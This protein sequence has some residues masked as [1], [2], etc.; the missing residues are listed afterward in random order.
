MERYVCLVISSACT[1]RRRHRPLC[2]AVAVQSQAKDCDRRVEIA[3]LGSAVTPSRRCA[4][5]GGSGQGGGG[6]GA[7]PPGVVAVWCARRRTM[8][9]AAAALLAPTYL[10]S[11][12]FPLT[13]PGLTHV[14]SLLPPCLSSIYRLAPRSMPSILRKLSLRSPSLDPSTPSPTR[15]RRGSALKN[16]LPLPLPD[17]PRRSRSQTPPANESLPE[18]PA[19]STSS[20]VSEATV[21][22]TATATATK[23]ADDGG[24]IGKRSVGTDPPHDVESANAADA[25]R[26]KPG[27]EQVPRA[28]LRRCN[29]AD[30]VGDKAASTETAQTTKG[31]P[32]NSDTTST[33]ASHSTFPSPLSN[34]DN[35]PGGEGSDFLPQN[36]PSNRASLSLNSV[37]SARRISF[38]PS[39]RNVSSPAPKPPL[40]ASLSRNYVAMVQAAE[41]A[42][43]LQRSH[44][45]HDQGSLGPQPWSGGGRS[46]RGRRPRPQTAPTLGTNSDSKAFGSG[47]GSLRTLM[48]LKR[49][50]P[51]EA[52]EGALPQDLFSPEQDALGS[53]H[54]E[55]LHTSQSQSNGTDSPPSMG[56]QVKDAPDSSNISKD[57]T[58]PPQSPATVH[59]RTATDPAA[60]QPSAPRAEQA[61]S[62]ET[63]T[64]VPPSETNAPDPLSLTSIPTR[65]LPPATPARKEHEPEVPPASAPA[66]L[67]VPTSTRADVNHAAEKAPFSNLDQNERTSAPPT[68]KTEQPNES[69]PSQKRAGSASQPGPDSPSGVRT[70]WKGPDRDPS[71]SRRLKSASLAVRLT[72]RLTKAFRSRARGSANTE[73]SSAR[74]SAGIAEEGGED[75][76]P[77]PPTRF[78]SREQ[79]GVT[80]HPQP[81]LLA[82]GGALT[83]AILV[84]GV[85]AFVPMEKHSDDPNRTDKKDVAGAA[86]QGHAAQDRTPRI[87]GRNATDPAGNSAKGTQRL[88]ES[89]KL[90]IDRSTPKR[91]T[92]QFVAGDVTPSGSRSPSPSPTPSPTPLHKGTSSRPSSAHAPGQA[93][94]HFKSDRG[95]PV[96]TSYEAARQEET[97]KSVGGAFPRTETM[98]STHSGGSGIY[99]SWAR[100]PVLAR[101]SSRGSAHT[102]SSWRSDLAERM[103]KAFAA[104]AGAIGTRRPRSAGGLA[105]A[106]G[107]SGQRLSEADLQR[108][109]GLQAAREMARLDR[110]IEDEFEVGG[111]DGRQG[112][113]GATYH[114]IEYNKRALAQKR[115]EPTSRATL[116]RIGQRMSRPSTAE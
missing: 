99:S 43:R 37:R 81:I 12:T 10:R 35:D 20:A 5:S 11:S 109:R 55:A 52:S 93:S 39:V 19:A 14:P 64:T 78:I 111:H 66:R 4:S 104:P 28:V 86:A 24:P 59:P 73:D 41:A 30:Q 82:P 95:R 80:A 69:V 75:T 110:E 23:D 71:P 84:G 72:A 16:T 54:A 21:T 92:I 2:C 53:P 85:E 45:P 94:I 26:D 32:S 113:K 70:L 63:E 112:G 18:S 114:A 3:A 97:F 8:M 101:S 96:S 36:I 7:A 49:T 48:L 115:T 61:A 108:L 56:D 47:T 105:Q 27:Y 106:R 67:G 100:T 15:K 60:S 102:G 29:S 25:A 42:E 57:V 40:P 107:R 31:S 90:D 89:D 44:G 98:D 116:P 65:E 79:H 87:D 51:T 22:V 103:S 62:T 76:L 50:R 83:P 46:G 77:A 88:S 1:W 58:P 9:N 68:P 74:V 33:A 91:T 17:Q 13:V 38:A 34:N 6:R